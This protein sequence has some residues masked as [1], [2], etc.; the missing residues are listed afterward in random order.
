MICPGV[1]NPLVNRFQVPASLGSISAVSRVRSLILP[2]GMSAGS[3]SRTAAGNRAYVISFSQTSLF[4]GI[5][6]LCELRISSK[7]NLK[8]DVLMTFSSLLRFITY[9]SGMW[10]PADRSFHV[11]QPFLCRHVKERLQRRPF[12]FFR[13]ENA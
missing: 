7:K 4:F 1:H 11:L 6:S 5:I 8:F 9:S 3:F 2:E 13:G 10:R 12:I